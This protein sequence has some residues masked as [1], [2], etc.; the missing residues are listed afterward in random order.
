MLSLELNTSNTIGVKLTV[1][2]KITNLNNLEV[3]Q[4]VLLMFLKALEIS[5]QPGNLELWAMIFNEMYK[6][7]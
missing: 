6:R 4:Q 3:K 2:P 5:N 1:K 7:V